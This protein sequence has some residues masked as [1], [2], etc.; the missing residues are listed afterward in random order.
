MSEQDVASWQ[1]TIYLMRSPANAR[2]LLE[3]LAEVEGGRTEHHEPVAL[4]DGE[5]AE[6]GE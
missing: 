6:D 2:R 5:D 4:P 3:S 1:E